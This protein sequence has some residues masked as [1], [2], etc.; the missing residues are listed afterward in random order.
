VAG[1]CDACIVVESADKG[2]SLITANMASGYS[3]EVFAFPGRNCD[4]RSK[5]C[6][7]LIKKQVAVL[8]ESAEDVMREMNWDLPK[9]KMKQQTILFPDLSP[10]EASLYSFMKTG[11]TYDGNNLAI[12]M[13]RRMGDILSSLMQLEMTGLIETLPGGFYRK[14]EF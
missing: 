5:G 2:G 14:K 1:L 8:V 11:E 3:R 13:D 12:L 7:L 6:N 4:E 9:K 10:S